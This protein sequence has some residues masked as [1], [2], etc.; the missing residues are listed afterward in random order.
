[1]AVGEGVILASFSKEV[2]HHVANLQ[3]G[4][5]NLEVFHLDILGGLDFEVARDSEKKLLIESGG[6][7]QTYVASDRFYA[8]INLLLEGA[9]LVVNDIEVRM[10][11]PSI[12]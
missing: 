2:L 1:M 10:A 9:V 8:L 7:R 11:N 6:S 3:E 5:L 12:H 4:F